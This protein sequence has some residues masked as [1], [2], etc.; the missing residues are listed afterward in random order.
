MSKLHFG[1]WEDCRTA[2]SVGVCR[3]FQILLLSLSPLCSQGEESNRCD[4]RC[5]RRVSCL[6]PNGK[7]LFAVL[8]QFEVTSLVRTLSPL[9][10]LQITCTFFLTSDSF[11]FTMLE[12]E[13]M[14]SDLDLQSFKSWDAGDVLVEHSVFRVLVLGLQI[15][16]L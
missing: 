2:S 8:L 4:V 11:E 6:L 7:L 5:E 12:S 16:T 1:A 13:S 9:Y 14:A 3:V 15:N 10:F